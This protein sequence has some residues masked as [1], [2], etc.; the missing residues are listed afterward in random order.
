MKLPRNLIDRDTLGHMRVGEV[1]YTTPW[2]MWV[3]ADMERW[4]HPNYVARDRPGG[5]VSMRVRRD[6]DGYV[7]FPPSDEKYA[8]TSRQPYAGGRRCDL[9]TGRRHRRQAMIAQ[10]VARAVLLGLLALLFIPDVPLFDDPDSATV[11]LA[12][13]VALFVVLMAACAA[14]VWLLMRLIGLAFRD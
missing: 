5:T 9:P 4:L 13:A 2:A 14:T 8:P 12:V 3:D 6:V 10:Y 7:V 11:P 1:A